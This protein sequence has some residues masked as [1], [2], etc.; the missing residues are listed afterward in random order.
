MADDCPDYVLSRNPSIL[1]SLGGNCHTSGVPAMWG[2][3]GFPSSVPE[4]V[5][6]KFN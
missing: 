2:K 6:R 1:K 5:R 4:K 3:E